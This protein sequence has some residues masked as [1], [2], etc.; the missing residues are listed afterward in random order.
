[1][2][3]ELQCTLGGLSPAIYVCIEDEG[4]SPAMHL[5]YFGLV[6][7]YSVYDM[8]EISQCVY[9]SYHIPA[10]LRLQ[11]QVP[12]V[13]LVS[14]T[15]VAMK[16]CLSMCLT[17][18]LLSTLEVI[19]LLQQALPS[20]LTGHTTFWQTQV[21]VRVRVKW[22]CVHTNRR[23]GRQMCVHTCMHT[24]VPVCVPICHA[25]L[26]HCIHLNCTCRCCCCCSI[27][28]N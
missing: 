22:A 20:S 6:H 10:L 1:M 26:Y 12:L 4:D 15:M 7:H 9:G 24:C 13:S 5:L 16:Y 2:Y 3:I 14:L 23:V 8:A 17:L 28:P 18:L 21:C 11:D 25:C 27:L 19:S